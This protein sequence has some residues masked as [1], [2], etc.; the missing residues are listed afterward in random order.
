[1]L[2]GGRQPIDSSIDLAAAVA[3]IRPET[4]RIV[5]A[6]AAPLAGTIETVSFVGDRLRISVRGAS[7]RPINVEASNMVQ[8]KLGER[9]GLSIAPEA[10]RLLPPED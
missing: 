1:V 7:E 5:D 10:I 4:I 9:V 3:M 8:A 2:P 6:S